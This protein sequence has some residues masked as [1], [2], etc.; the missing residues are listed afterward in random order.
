MPMMTKILAGAAGVAAIAAAA[1][2]TAQYYPYGYNAYGYVAPS[3]YSP[4]AYS[5]Y[6]TYA[7][8]PTVAAQQCTAAVQNRLYNRTSISSIIGAVLGV[9]TASSARVVGITQTSPTRSGMRVRGVASSG[10]YAYNSYGPYGV[11]A[12]GALGYNYA[13]AAD[14][15]FRCDV[16]YRG[17]VRD[18][19]ITRR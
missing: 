7:V 4:Y 2:A 16:D 18:V 13:Q 3:T 10:R 8:N 1:P 5:G 9:N 19:D 6:R 12:Y 15:K 11:G 17:Y 14:L